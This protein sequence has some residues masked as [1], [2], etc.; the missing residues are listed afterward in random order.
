[1]RKSRKP[2]K[3]LKLGRAETGLGLFTTK[4]IKRSQFIAE[5]AGKIISGEEADL[6]NSRYLFEISKNVVID[7]GGRE[8]IARYINHS[9]KPNCYAEI[10]GRRIYIYAKKLIPIGEELTY[11]Y[12]KEYF[13][14]FIKPYGCKCQNYKNP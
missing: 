4:P 9:C 14:E 13:N 8:N 12:G 3:G 6:K 10:D 11:N 1:M 5:Y 2:R 7:G